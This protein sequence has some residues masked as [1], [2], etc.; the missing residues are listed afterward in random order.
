MYINLLLF[1]YLSQLRFSWEALL[2]LYFVILQENLNL[3]TPTSRVSQADEGHSVAPRQSR[4]KMVSAEAGLSW[5]PLRPY[6]TGT[7]GSPHSQ[8]H[9]PSSTPPPPAAVP[10]AQA[11]RTQHLS[12]CSA[13]PVLWWPLRL[14]WKKKKKLVSVL[15]ETTRKCPWDSLVFA[16]DTAITFCKLEANITIPRKKVFLCSFGRF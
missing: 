14:S 15:Y 7:T 4:K 2:L 11:A 6:R 3:R 8:P 13:S 9:C 1:I 16:C 5:L 10:L 12:F